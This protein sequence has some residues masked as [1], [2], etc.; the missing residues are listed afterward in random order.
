MS[1]L[2]STGSNNSFVH[3]RKTVTLDEVYKA[4]EGNN[5]FGIYVTILAMIHG[6]LSMLS[7]SIP[8]LTKFP[9]M[10]CKEA[11]CVD[12]NSPNTLHNWITNM[13]LYTTSSFKLGLIGSS[14]FVG[15]LLGSVTF[16]R[17]PDR[18]G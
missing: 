6:Y 16:L 17:L 3:S 11:S 8:F 18:Y 14:F 12:Y 4:T 1:S 2:Y 5:K 9:E 13:H 15:Y 7:Y 10:S